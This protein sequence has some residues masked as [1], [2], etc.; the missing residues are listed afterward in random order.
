METIEFFWVQSS[1]NKIRQ[2]QQQ[3]QQQNGFSSWEKTLQKI[4][5]RNDIE[6]EVR[7]RRKLWN[8]DST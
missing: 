1:E 8:I 6:K 5:R 4:E 3:Q 2:Q 7:R